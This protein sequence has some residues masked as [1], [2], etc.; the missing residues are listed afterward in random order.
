MKK[1]ESEKITMNCW[2]SKKCGRETNGSKV[3][4]LGVCP[5]YSRNAGQACWLVMGTFYSGKAQ[6]TFAG[7][8]RDCMKCDFFQQF[9][10]SH[11][12]AMSA[13]FETAVVS[14]SFKRHAN[15]LTGI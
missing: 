8:A 2:E 9:D 3:A 10:I 5:A 11:R 12:A 14:I 15:H 1:Q 7:K 4:E 6:E 13:K